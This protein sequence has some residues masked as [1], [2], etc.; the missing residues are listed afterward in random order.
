MYELVRQG[1]AIVRL[2][3]PGGYCLK[4]VGSAQRRVNDERLVGSP[5]HPSPHA[6]SFR[7]ES[8]EQP[9]LSLSKRGIP[10]AFIRA[11]R[12]EPK[13][14]PLSFRGVFCRG[15]PEFL[16][17]AQNTGAN[18]HSDHSSLKSFQVGLSDLIRSIFLLRRQLLI[19]FYLAMASRK[20][21]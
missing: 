14:L 12:T 8:M 20:S 7:M 6:L 13:R 21:W 15:I 10:R 11:L 19:C 16:A 2:N 18:S 1:V 4:G 17:R 3:A 5:C 9:A